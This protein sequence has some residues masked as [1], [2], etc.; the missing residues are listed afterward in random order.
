LK[1]LFIRDLDGL[2]NEL[3]LYENEND[4][5]KVEGDITNTAGNLCLHLVGNLQ[6]FIGKELGKTDYVRVWEREFSLKNVS[7]QTLIKQVEEAKE[8]SIKNP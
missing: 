8:I 5:W 2:I 7:R 4:M 6:H 1:K 3:K